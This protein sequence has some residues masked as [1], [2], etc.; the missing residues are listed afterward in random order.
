MTQAS[1]ADKERMQCAMLLLSHN[2]PLNPERSLF[3]A[4][5]GPGCAPFDM[6]KF[7][8]GTRL[9]SSARTAGFRSSSLCSASQPVEA[10]GPPL[11]HFH[12]LSPVRAPGGRQLDLVLI[13]VR[14][15]SLDSVGM[16]VLTH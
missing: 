3:G 9:R 12:P 13:A 15:R 7:L 5:W 11:R 6:P 16:P 14:Q 4:D 10:V 2:H 1:Q 8:A